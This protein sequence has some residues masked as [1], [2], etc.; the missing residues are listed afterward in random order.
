MANKNKQKSDGALQFD[1]EVL[2]ASGDSALDRLEQ[3]GDR[4][5][6]LV[7]AWIRASNAAAVHEVAWSEKVSSGVRKVARRGL[8]VLRSRGVALPEKVKKT[9]A[10]D[11]G[12]TFE[13][14]YLVPDHTGV[15]VFTLAS[16]T[17]GSHLH[18]VDV[19]VHRDAGVI[20]VNS[21]EIT[22]GNLRA[23][24]KNIE[25]AR[26][27]GPVS[28]PV[29]WARWRVERAKKQNAVSGLVLPLGF[30]KAADL[31]TPVP[32]SLPAHPMDTED[33]RFDDALVAQS[34][35][36]SAN[37]HS[38]PEFAREIP[39]LAAMQEVLQRVGERYGAVE[40]KT[41]EVLRDL[42]A[43]ELV[44][45][46]DRYFTPDARDRL[47]EAMRDVAISVCARAGKD[48]AKQILAVAEAVK[49]AG[50]ITSPPSDIPFLK[51]FFDKGIAVLAA[52]TGGKL[53][54]PMPNPVARQGVAAPPEVFEEVAKTRTGARWNEEGTPAEEEPS[55]DEP[56]PPDIATIEVPT[57]MAQHVEAANEP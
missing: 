55:T 57:D 22:R 32:E 51:I 29:E 23:G 28:V 42:L 18:L 34:V 39:T 8:N 3:V 5:E 47:A 37:L 17:V 46:T 21:G 53:S 38:E 15:G 43:E 12:A 33:M 4:A 13:A 19:Q 6:A 49:R 10:E 2:Q 1:P 7:E 16:C 56:A 44:V 30:A 35:A 20:D 41:D 50:L 40:D 25:Q 14:W 31:L 26:G 54:I 9:V 52:T 24:F 11:D 48:R 45:A 27:F 36:A